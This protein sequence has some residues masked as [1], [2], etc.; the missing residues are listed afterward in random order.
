MVSYF[1]RYFSSTP[2]RTKFSSTSTEQI[3]PDSAG[4]FIV[5]IRLALL[6]LLLH[7]DKKENTKRLRRRSGSIGEQLRAHW[8]PPVMTKGV[9][10]EE[11]YQRGLM[12]LIDYF[13]DFSG[14]VPSQNMHPRVMDPCRYSRPDSATTSCDRY[15]LRAPSCH[16]R[17]A[18]NSCVP[19]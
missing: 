14:E 3:S 15:R 5:S 17:P 1:L 10:D 12:M 9:L 8:S 16:R 4:P 11:P 2:N 7:R 6:F 18:R 13:A 19:N